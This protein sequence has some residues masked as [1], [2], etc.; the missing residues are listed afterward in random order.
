MLFGEKRVNDE[1]TDRFEARRL[2]QASRFLQ[3]FVPHLDTPEKQR[4]LLEYYNV[5]VGQSAQAVEDIKV[6]TSL[7][8]HAIAATERR[9]AQADCANKNPDGDEYDLGRRGAFRS[10]S[11]LMGVF[12]PVEKLKE[13][14]P[15]PIQEIR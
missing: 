12:A 11:I 15:N 9:C 4:K 13:G 6:V 8:A 1:E 10:F 14:Q 3:Q 5:L 7:D 2:N